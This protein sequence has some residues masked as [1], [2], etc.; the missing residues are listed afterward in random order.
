M[1][2]KD[3]VTIV[4]GA[5]SGI[6]KEIAII[7]PREG[8]KVAITDLDQKAADATAREVD[9]TGAR[10]QIRDRFA[11]RLP[12]SPPTSSISRTAASSTTGTARTI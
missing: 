11:S 10:N 5:A 1:R 2:L 4:T 9:P 8:A 12:S 7:F 6:E 3:K